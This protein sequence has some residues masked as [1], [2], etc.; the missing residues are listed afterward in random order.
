[1]SE[2]STSEQGR[3]FEKPC[4]VRA[5]YEDKSACGHIA[6]RDGRFDGLNVGE[7]KSPFGVRLK[8]FANKPN[9]LA[10]RG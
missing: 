7:P 8:V 9:F 6:P 10:A 5:F 3:K 4:A 2:Q 1:M